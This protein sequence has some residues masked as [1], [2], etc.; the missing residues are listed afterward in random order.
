[1]KK[2][3]DDPL[4]GVRE[5]IAIRER[6]LN[7]VHERTVSPDQIADLRRKFRPASL[8]AVRRRMNVSQGEFARLIG[9]PTTTVQNWE[10]GRVRPTGPALALLRVATRNPRAVVEALYA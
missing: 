8:K 3:I 10:Q 2:M 5:F 9:V 1:M 6:K 7:G 4:Q